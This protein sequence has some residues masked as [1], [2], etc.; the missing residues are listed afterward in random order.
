[1]KIGGQIKT[2]VH[3][4]LWLMMIKLIFKTLGTIEFVS[5]IVQESK[6]CADVFLKLPKKRNNFPA[7]L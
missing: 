2:M 3:V 1:M 7:I 4:Q 5:H 6:I